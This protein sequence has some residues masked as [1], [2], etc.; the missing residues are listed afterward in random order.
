MWLR[1]AAILIVMGL[2]VGAALAQT[3][4]VT[5]TITDQGD[6]PLPGA[7][8]VVV[9]D[10]DVGAAA[11][12]DGSY[13]ISGLEPGTY[14]LRASFIGY[15][16]QTVSVSIEA[17]ETTRQNFTLSSAPM[18]M[19]Q[20]TVL[21]SRSGEMASGERAVPVDV[22]STEELDLTGNVETGEILQALSPSVNFPQQPVADQTSSVRPLT[23]R[24]LSPDQTLVLVNGKRRHRSSAVQVFS[25]GSTSGA[26]PVDFNSFPASA[27]ERVEVLRDGA[28]AQYGSDAIAGVVNI[29]LKEGPAPASIDIRTSQFVPD[30]FSADGRKFSVSGNWGTKVGEGSLNLSLQFVDRNS[31]NR[32]GADSR[33]QIEPGDADVV[34]EDDE[35]VEK[36]NPVNQP[37][38][39][40]GLG[41]TTNIMTFANFRYP[42]LDEAEEGTADFYL[43]GGV[44]KRSSQTWGFRRRGI[45]NRNIPEIFPQGFLP[46]FEPDISDGSINAGIEGTWREWDFDVSAGFGRN[47]FD[48]NITN[49][50]NASLPPARNQTEF[51]AG[52]TSFNETIGNIDLTRG[53]DVGLAGPLNVSFGGAIR[54]ENWTQSRGELASWVQGPRD[55]PAGSQVFPGFQPSNEDDL[56]RNNF[57]FYS[58]LEAELTDWLTV[59]TAGRFESYSDFGETLTGKFAVRAEPVDWLLL[60]GSVSSGFRA[61]GL[62]QSGYSATSTNFVQD[63]ETGETVAVEEGIFSVDSE[64]AQRLGA[65]PLEEEQSTNFSGGV[66]I[67]PLSNLSVSADFFYV[68][69]R[70]RVILSGTLSGPQVEQI[71]SDV[72]ATAA[73]FFVNALDTETHGVDLT[74]DYVTKIGDDSQL[75]LSGSFNYTKTDITKVK[76]PEVLQG[77][78]QAQLLDAEA[79]LA[80]EEEAPET[81]ARLTGR[82]TVGGFHSQ[83]RL[84]Y[85]GG[86]E[87]A[88]WVEPQE[89]S[90]K[91]LTDIE[92]G[93]DIMDNVG[94]SMGINNVFDVFPDEMNETNEL[95][96]VFTFPRASPFGFN[97]REVYGRLSIEL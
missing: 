46:S 54:F 24:N 25:S 86:V 75:S 10:E 82:Y 89:Y 94:F 40:W 37:N 45:D 12:E 23:L 8:V 13:T 69:V 22:Y 35:V 83:V 44:S 29:V 93:Y 43:F 84:R 64:T 34:N 91:G 57:A 51:F 47:N 4:E 14:E 65:V 33:D 72:P 56:S 36:N 41:E 71:L 62:A 15:T 26:A 68:E 90:G 2:F 20:V 76:L 27:I 5:G 3:G 42:L 48:F 95:F 67:S 11:D 92:L 79:R 28:A 74:A 9:G 59:N 87:S 63:P 32:A 39:Q 52:S 61:P 19:E 50:L 97:G 80:I 60:R 21:G 70:D 96:D 85:F 7:Q 73:R 30:E 66:T 38:H 1:T 78:E 31:T 18:G 81:Q 77:L 58:D 6:N 88:L 53:V 49:T 16:G 17:G 55:G